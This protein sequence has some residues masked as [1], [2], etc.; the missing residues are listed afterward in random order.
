MENNSSEKY[1]EQLVFLMEDKRLYLISDLSS[2]EVAR[3]L[4][5]RSS[6]LN[7]LL[8]ENLGVEI[9]Q[10]I[11][12]YRIQ[13]AREM[14]TMGVRYRELWRFSGFSSQSNMDRAFEDIVY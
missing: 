8:Y 12:M 3:L 9:G 7:N 11:S 4:K 2:H 10:I 14:L 6:C 5:I 1:L 13:H